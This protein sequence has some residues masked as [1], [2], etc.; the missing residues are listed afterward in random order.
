MAALAQKQTIGIVMTTGLVVGS[1]I[2]SG[3]FMLPVALAPLGA[4]AIAGWVVSVFGALAIAFAL[5][6]LTRAGDAGIQSFIEQ[7]FG[8]TVGFLV[9]WA[10]WCSCWSAQAAIAI[11]FGAAMSRVTPVLASP[12]MIVAA[13]VAATAFL[14]LVNAFGVRASGGLNLIT[15]IIKIAPLVGVVVLLALAGMSGAP[16]EPLAP[17]PLNVSNIATATTLTL[18]ALTG[19][20]NVTTLIGKVHKPERTLP[21][22][23]LIG[24]T[25]VGLVYL[26]SSTA[27]TFLLPAE[28][29]AS[30][31]APYADIFAAYGGEPV[32]RVAALAIAVS[33]F[34]ALNCL[35]LAAGEL[36][37]AMAI[38]RQLP[39]A[40]TRVRAGNAP[41]ASQI[42]G[43]GMAILLVLANSNRSTAGL[44]SFIILISTSAVLVVYLAGVLTAW[45][46]SHSIGSRA[47]ILIALL[48]VLFAFYGSGAEAD[49]W[50]LALMAV[51]LAVLIVMRGINSR[52]GSSPV[53]ALHPV[54]PPGSSA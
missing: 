26:L 25:L 44:F 28:I 8:P 24:V 47:L 16:L 54:G 11:A 18:F 52:A 15:V 1:M 49:L 10:F 22:A 29:V 3:I 2:G 45:R 42:F 48:F 6:R 21:R 23:I 51:G 34:G 9:T 38:R 12:D 50:V 7:A 5:A 4:N 36:G 19:F 27:V 41:Y 32:V 13:A 31:P 37:Y 53:E 35:V 39:A 43:A 14:A 20:E 30:S 17:T 40:M 46:S 33:A